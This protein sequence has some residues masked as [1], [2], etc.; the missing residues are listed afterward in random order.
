MSINWMKVLPAFIA[1]IDIAK[2]IGAGKTGKEKLQ[3]ALDSADQVMD[4]LEAGTDKDLFN[5]PAVLAAK[6]N[7]VS[8]IYDLE[9]LVE[10]VKQAKGTGG[11]PQ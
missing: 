4:V 2:K 1:G 7:V 5:N 3:I 11:S 10:N 6:A 8:A 9:K